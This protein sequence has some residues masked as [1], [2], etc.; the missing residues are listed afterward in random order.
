MTNKKEQKRIRNIKMGK[1]LRK[2]RIKLKRC[3]YCN[4][5]LKCKFISCDACRNRLRSKAQDKCRC[6]NLKYS[7]SKRCKQCFFKGNKGV[8]NERTNK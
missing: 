3:V 7:G 6:G 1:Q 4:I 2:K 5:K 8:K